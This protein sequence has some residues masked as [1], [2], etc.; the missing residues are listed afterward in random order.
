MTSGIRAAV[1]RI[2]RQHAVTEHITRIP[3]QVLG[4]IQREPDDLLGVL[5]LQWSSIDVR[6]EAAVVL[7]AQIFAD[8]NNKTRPSRPRRN[9]RRARGRTQTFWKARS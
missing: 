7:A 1:N 4:P 6:R 5:A 8:L 2:V 9:H 3:L